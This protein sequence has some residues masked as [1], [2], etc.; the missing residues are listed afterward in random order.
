MKPAVARLVALG[1]VVGISFSAI[2]VR[3]ANVAPTTAAFFRS[4]YAIPVLLLIWWALRGRDRRSASRRWMAFGSGILLAVDLV[5][6][7]QSIAWLG[8]GLAT[9]VANIQVAFVGVAAWILYRERPSRLAFLIVPVAFLGVAL[10]SGL[11][12]S[13]AYGARPAAGTIAAVL[14]GATYAGFLLVFRASNRNLAP[15]HGP[16]LDATLGAAAGSLAVGFFDAGFDVVPVWP[17]HGWLLGL[18]VAVQVGGWV[19]IATALPR[20][21]ALETS[22]LLLLQPMLTVVWAVFIFS[23]SL[24]TVQWLG[25]A[26]VLGGIAALSVRGSVQA[27][28]AGPA[29]AEA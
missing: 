14:A 10:I 13:D 1:G 2:F 12:R 16:L 20:L 7:H 17:A 5:L 29:L 15:P 26:L 28:S 22:V 25:V 27:P 4:A 18:A 23:E 24:S 8:A 11:G 21:P 19:L 9:V 6:W 3:L